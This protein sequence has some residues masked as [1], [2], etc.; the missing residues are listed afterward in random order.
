MRL[1]NDDGV[2][3]LQQRIGLRLRQQDAIGHQLDAALLSALITESDL[4][5]DQLSQR[6]MQLLG[7]SGGH[8]TGRNAARL[9]VADLLLCSTPQC[10]ADLRELGGLAGA[11]LPAE[12][13][14]L[15]VLDGLGNLLS[16]LVDRQRLVKVDLER[17]R[18]THDGFLISICN[19]LLQKNIYENLGSNDS[20]RG[21]GQSED[22]Y[23]YWGK[24]EQ[25]EEGIRCHLLPYHALDVA[26]VAACWVEQSS[27]LHDRLLGCDNFTG[28]RYGWLLFFVALHD[29]G[30]FDFRFQ[31]KVDI[32]WSQLND[33]FDPDS[34]DPAAAIGFDHG[35]AGYAW[36]LSEAEAAGFTPEANGL[37]WMEAVAKH[38]GV[39][40]VSGIAELYGLDADPEVIEQD[41]QAR[42]S[43]IEALVEL[44]LLSNGCQRDEIPLPFPL[45]AGFCSV[46]DWIGS[47]SNE[48]L[49]VIND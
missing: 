7:D 30:K 24:A 45:L 42:S 5:T 44:F 36:W 11:G 4:E 43:W 26:A 17:R 31:R 15:T 37:A 8:R 34:S 22:F 32:A 33:R 40:E 39:L 29:V 1:I 13:G 9:G 48:K 38:H 20:I 35:K 16:P 21:M 41:Q 14:D 6:G 28:Q 25:S 12:D 3:L 49:L 46:C 27:V 19:I 23:S 2:I 47:Q 18:V 10:E